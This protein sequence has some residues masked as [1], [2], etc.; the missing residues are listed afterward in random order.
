MLCDF[1]LSSYQPGAASQLPLLLISAALFQVAHSACAKHS[2]T[3]WGALSS[4]STPFQYANSRACLV[5]PQQMAKL[6]EKSTKSVAQAVTK[7]EKEKKLVQGMDDGDK[8]QGV[9]SLTSKD[10]G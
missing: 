6:G 3:C 10:C 7:S 5:W 9:S 1:L 2:N 8:G 4:G